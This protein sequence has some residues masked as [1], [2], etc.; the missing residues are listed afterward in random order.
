MVTMSFFPHGATLEAGL[1]NPL[2]ALRN[3]VNQ[4][5][6]LDPAAGADVS[7]T[8]NVLPESAT[9]AWTKAGTQGA[10]VAAGV[11]TMTDTDGNDRI[12]Y[13][14]NEAGVVA[15]S[16]AWLAVRTQV[17]SG[18][19]SSTGLLNG[20]N[21]E[22]WDGARRGFYQIDDHGVWQ[23]SP[24]ASNNA[25]AGARA[26]FTTSFR[27]V[28]I[29]KKT[30]QEFQVYIDGLP[31]FANGYSFSENSAG[32]N[33]FRF[34]TRANT[35]TG[36]IRIE[37]VKYR[38]SSLWPSSSPG[39]TFVLDSGSDDTVWDLSSLK[40]YENLYGEAGS[41]RYQFAAG[42]S[43]T[44]GALN[45]S[46]LT[47]VQ[48][49]AAS[50]PTGRYLYLRVVLV[51]NGAQDAGWGGISINVML[52]LEEPETPDTTPPNA[53][54][55][56]APEID[57]GEVTIAYTPPGSDYL[58]GEIEY[59]DG[60][61]VA[62]FDV[63]GADYYTIDGLTNGVRYTFTARARDAAG[64]WSARSLARAA[65]PIAE[66]PEDPF[67]LIEHYMS[68]SVRKWARDTGIS[69]VLQEQ[70]HKPPADESIQD[71]ASVDLSSTTRR[72]TRPDWYGATVRFQIEC[73]S[74][75]ASQRVDKDMDAPWRLASRFR[76]AFEKKM[77]PVMNYGA[78]S[79]GEDTIAVLKVA[80]G[81]AVYDRGFGESHSVIVTFTAVLDAVA[82]Q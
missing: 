44:P 48:L 70:G 2:A 79:S 25:L 36:T 14:R 38:I 52:S 24:S 17:V 28:E 4:Y 31:L 62:T 60:T 80:E 63:T 68:L 74:R 26:D 66:P 29:C 40:S 81:E 51:G 46:N 47:Q 78:S 13:F 7:Y 18:A 33:G 76:S 82:V 59:D 56:G 72:R 34:S 1:R 73:V 32:N 75:M 23:T 30:N 69:P 53:P 37:H 50:D 3:G 71:W 35:G 77:I 11:L 15:G 5:L 16:S 21:V 41:V 54:V 27:T 64:N 20:L 22:I 45:G 65:M 6:N 49:A 10:A 55:L 67:D 42:N 9:P 8:P 43:V 39:T 19:H 12:D 61:M 58:D 57:D